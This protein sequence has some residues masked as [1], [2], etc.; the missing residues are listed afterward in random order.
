MTLLFDKR[1]KPVSKAWS[2][3]AL[4]QLFVNC[5][6]HRAGSCSCAFCASFPGTGKEHHKRDLFVYVFPIKSAENFCLRA[7]RI[8]K[9][10]WPALLSPITEWKCAEVKVFLL[11]LCLWPGNFHQEPTFPPASLQSGSPAHFPTSQPE[12]RRAFGNLNFST[13]ISNMIPCRVVQCLWEGV[14]S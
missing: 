3:K 10:R 13:L 12:Q 6:N 7:R 11:P 8:R 9:F 5:A 14:P 1:F 4:S 2:T